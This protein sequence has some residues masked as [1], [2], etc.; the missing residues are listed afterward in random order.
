[1][2][3]LTFKCKCGATIR[4][5]SGDAVQNNEALRAFWQSH[6]APECGPK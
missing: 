2:S 6:N 5:Y 1:M 4:L 3:S